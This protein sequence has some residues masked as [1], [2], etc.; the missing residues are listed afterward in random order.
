[1]SE[2][3]QR[4]AQFCVDLRFEDLP[5]ALVA[6]AKRH[7][8]DTF[9][10]TLAGADSGVAEQ[11]GKVFVGET[12]EVSVWGTDLQVNAAQAAMLNGVAAHALELDDTGGCDHSGAVVLPAV[13]AAVSLL[14]RPVNG[15][16]FICAVVIGYEVGR[17]VLEACGG[18]SAHNGAG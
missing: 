18:Y 4:L 13:M 9:G 16:E 2:R 3:L 7:I 10:A 1:M 8:L 11:A 17:R 14:A 12:G 6:Q 5:P 15:R